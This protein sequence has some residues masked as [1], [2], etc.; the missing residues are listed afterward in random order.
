MNLIDFASSPLSL[1]PPLVALSLA[2][3]TRRVLVSLGVGILLGALLLTNYS[4]VDGSSYVVTKVASVFVEDGGLN[5]WNMSIVGFLLLLGMMTA[6]LTLSGGT[7]AFAE[8]AQ[9]RVKSKRGSKLLAAFLGVFIFVDDYFN[10][11]AVGSISRPVTDRFYVSRAKLAYIL[12][13]T[14][15]PMCVVMPASSWGAYIMT[16]IGGILVSH[17]ITEYS[18][19]GAYIRLVPMNFYAIFALLMV[20]AVVWFQL[21]VGQ[22]R[23]H[24]MEASQGRGFDDDNDSQQAHDLNE[25]LDIKESEHGK[26]SDLILP[27]VLLII[28]TISAMLYTGGQSLAADGKAFDLF[29]AFEN[30]D[31]G[32]S[33][34]HGGLVGLAMALFTVFKQQLPMIDVVKTLWIG[35]KSMFGAILILVFAWTIGSVIG[36]MKTGAYMSS[37][38]QGNIN[39][40]W[41]PVIL[42]LLSGLMAFSTGTSWGTFGIMLPI[43]GDMAGATDIALMLPMLSAVLAGSVF[44]DHCSPISDTTILSSTGARCNHIDHVSTQL[45]YALATA[46]VS[47][48]GF[49]VLGM[50]ASVL[51]SFSAASVT[52]VIVCLVLA[53]LSRSKITNY[54][55]A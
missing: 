39:P 40:H 43:A 17:G 54:E 55:N 19:L 31:V 9:V 26:V 27:I 10:S 33:L 7:R 50:T 45:P 47:C 32:T 2:V 8:W 6:L 44:G 41:L 28:A 12:D 35:A 14:A 13:S 52:F 38:V 48:V 25:E 20:F 1:L 18:A 11:L 49:V 15:A 5:T 46:L 29:G 3:I 37:L 34:I 53:S 16:I 21:D 42:F 22:M 36:D 4:V 23:K 30:T 51:I 24:E